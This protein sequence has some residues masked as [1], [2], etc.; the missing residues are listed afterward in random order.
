MLLAR[1]KLLGQITKVLGFW[2]TPPPPHRIGKT[3]K[4]SRIFFLTGSLKTMRKMRKMR[5]IQKNEDNEENDNSED[6]KD[7]EDNDIEKT[8]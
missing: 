4:K 8:P 7:N 5:T 2:E 1:Q 6:Y 3:P